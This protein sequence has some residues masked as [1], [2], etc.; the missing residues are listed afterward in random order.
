M[1]RICC[2]F[3]IHPGRK[4][5]E[6]DFSS[7]GSFIRTMRNTVLP[8]SFFGGPNGNTSSVDNAH[9]LSNSWVSGLKIRSHAPA[10]YESFGRQGRTADREKC[11]PNPG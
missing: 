10:S 3:I 5:F 2:E 6:G 9:D 11:W 1:V 8:M 7:C 4:E